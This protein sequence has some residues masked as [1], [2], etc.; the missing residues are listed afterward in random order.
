MS[1]DYWVL[2]RNEGLDTIHRNPREPCNTDDADGRQTIDARTADEMLTRGTA[3]RCGHCMEETD[4]T[5]D[6]AG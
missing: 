3:R 5:P 2:N 1:T 6:P 4:G